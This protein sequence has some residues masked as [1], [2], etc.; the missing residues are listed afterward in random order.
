[1]VEIN[2]CPVLSP[3]LYNFCHHMGYTVPAPKSN[4]NSIPLFPLFQTHTHTNTHTH[5]HT[6]THTH[7]HTQS[8]AERGQTLCI[9]EGHLG[10]VTAGHS[11]YK[12]IHLISLNC[13]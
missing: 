2:V 9:H 7:T 4:N 11:N 8:P 5:T 3:S 6:L 10:L 1:M 13:P 12:V